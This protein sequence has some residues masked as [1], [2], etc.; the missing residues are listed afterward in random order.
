MATKATTRYRLRCNSAWHMASR[1]SFPIRIR[2]ACV[3]L[4]VSMESLVR[5]LQ[6][7]PHEIRVER[8]LTVWRRL[9]S[10]ENRTTVVQVVAFSGSIQRHLA[11][12]SRGLSGPVV[13]ERCGARNSYGRPERIEEVQLHRT[14][15]S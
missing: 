4:S 12:K 2:S 10:S 14:A 9:R 5:R 7:S 15:K 13:L 3:T 6:T 8:V 1:G 11:Q